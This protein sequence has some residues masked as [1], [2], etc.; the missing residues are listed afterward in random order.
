M[1]S[2]TGELKTGAAGVG[3][4]LGAAGGACVGSGAQPKLGIRTIPKITTQDPI[5]LTIDI[6]HLLNNIPY[7][8]Q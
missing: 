2:F 3:G 4:E 8:K 5:S 1:P 7:E 6:V